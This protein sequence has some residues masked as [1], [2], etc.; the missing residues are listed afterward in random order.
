MQSAERVQQVQEAISD[1]LKNVGSHDWA[2]VQKDFLEI[3]TSTF[4][5]YV[6]KA[7][8]QME[9]PVAP[10]VAADLFSREEPT[11]DQSEPWEKPELNSTFRLLRHAQRFYELHADLLALRQHAL[12]ANGKIRDAQLFAKAIRLRSQLLKEELNV[13]DGIRETD[14]N[15]KFFDAIIETVAKASPE[16]A[17]A[18]MISL[19]ELNQQFNPSERKN[20]AA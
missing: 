14:V 17:K 3:P 6:T 12:D 1:H 19:N 18:I 11:G 15:T 20:K 2:D 7:K 13:V 5:R 16:V 8:E 4:W 9:R 10:N